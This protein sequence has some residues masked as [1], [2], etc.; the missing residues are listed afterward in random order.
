MMS[1][2]LVIFA[3]YL[4]VAVV[5]VVMG[6]TTL[7]GLPEVFWQQKPVFFPV[8]CMLPVLKTQSLLIVASIRTQQRMKVSVRY[9]TLHLIL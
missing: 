9:P 7:N 5:V 2:T 6:T 8:R 4:M 1:K 3:L